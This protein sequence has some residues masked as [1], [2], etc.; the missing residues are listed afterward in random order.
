MKKCLYVWTT[1]L[2]V[3]CPVQENSTPSINYSYD[4]IETLLIPW[5]G[6]FEVEADHYMALV[7]SKSCQHCLA[8]EDTVVGY[9]LSETSTPLFFIEATATI[10]KGKDIASTLGATSI[11]E[12]Y[13]LGWPSLLEIQNGTLVAHLAGEKAIA[14]KLG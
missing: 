1:M 6:L 14:Q 4:Q 13:I 3:S 5:G 7:F 11:D 9:A 8:I 10:P 12:M 2:L